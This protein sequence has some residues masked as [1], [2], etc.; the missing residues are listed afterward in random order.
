MKQLFGY[1]SKSEEKSPGRLGKE[2]EVRRY[3]VQ[4]SR[5]VVSNSLR[6]HGLLTLSFQGLASL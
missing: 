2:K 5:S 1:S 3:S 6:P 4:F